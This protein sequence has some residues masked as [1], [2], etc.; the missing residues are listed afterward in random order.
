MVQK[1][2][3]GTAAFARTFDCYDYVDCFN[4]MNLHDQLKLFKQGY[5]KVTDHACREIRHGRITR[6][7]GLALVRRHEQAQTAYVP[8]FLE[9]LGVTERSLQ[10]IMDQYRNKSYWK[11]PEFG[12]WEF[13]GWS[14]QQSGNGGAD[15]EQTAFAE[16]FEV[17]SRLEYDRDAKYI[18]VGKGYP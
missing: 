5:S 10:F 12:K 1:Y 13:D 14:A 7:Q 4:Y 2:Q 15:D 17:N 16:K 3:Y 8:Q 18:T 11:Q 6:E 9:W